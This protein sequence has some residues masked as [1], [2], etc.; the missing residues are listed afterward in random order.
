M[1]ATGTIRLLMQ[2]L[3][4]HKNNTVDPVVLL[5]NLLRDVDP[6]HGRAHNQVN[7]HAEN[8]SQLREP[9]RRRRRLA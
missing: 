9:R 6:R 5:A 7:N 3:R 1:D 8:A 4:A 2:S